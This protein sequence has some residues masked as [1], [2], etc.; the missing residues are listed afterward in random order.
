MELIRKRFIIK[1]TEVLFSPVQ[2]TPSPEYPGLQV[3]SK[4]PLVFLQIALAWQLCFPASHS[5]SS[6]IQKSGTESKN[7]FSFQLR[8]LK[9]G[10][11]CTFMLSTFNIP[12]VTVTREG[13]FSVNAHWNS[14]ITLVFFCITLVYVWKWIRLNYQTD[15]VR[16]LFLTNEG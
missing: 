5:F 4:N 7:W 2:L 3:H 1:K 16:F 15:Q 10:V 6:A 8:D 13:S 12:F 11:T 14:F 9:V